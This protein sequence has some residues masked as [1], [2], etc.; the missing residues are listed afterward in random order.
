M[1]VFYSIVNQSPLQNIKFTIDWSTSWYNNLILYTQLFTIKQSP[2][3]KIYF[4]EWLFVSTNDI[5]KIYVAFDKQIMNYFI[6]LFSH[7]I[8]DN[9][10]IIYSW[11]FCIVAPF[12]DSFFFFY[13]SFYI[14]LDLSST[15]LYNFKIENCF[16]L[17]SMEQALLIID[18]HLHVNRRFIIFFRSLQDKTYT[19]PDEP[20]LIFFRLFNH[21]L[22]FIKSIVLYTIYPLT[23][24]VYLQKIQCFC[25]EWFILKPFESV[26]LPVLFQLQFGLYY[27][28]QSYFFKSFY[29]FIS[30]IYNLFIITAT[31]K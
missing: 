25:F 13:F 10:I 4:L 26:D 9:K 29:Y 19:I 14:Y 11:I 2:D 6:D 22:F 21:S 16:Y 20:T 23:F 27:L 12:L 24:I 3:A 30:L 17:L 15:H 7:Y 8:L 28:L 1:S 18:L 31:T 5:F